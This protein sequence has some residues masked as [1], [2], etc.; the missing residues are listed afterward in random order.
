MGTGCVLGTKPLPS[1]SRA[2][3][4]PGFTLYTYFRHV[5]FIC[6]L[7][8]SEHAYG[9]DMEEHDLTWFEALFMRLA[10]WTEEYVSALFLACRQWPMN[11]Q[12][13]AGKV[14]VTL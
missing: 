2:S 5:L 6:G 10:R 8:N 4:H 9:T 14:R 11:L 1:Q 12:R 13:D 7:F 3:T